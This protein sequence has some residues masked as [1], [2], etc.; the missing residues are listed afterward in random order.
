GEEHDEP[1]L[2]AEVDDPVEHARSLAAAAGADRAL[3]DLGL[4]EE[5]SRRDHLLA[6]LE[7]GPGKLHE[8]SDRVAG[9]DAPRLVE[10]ALL[11]DE[12]DERD[13]VPLD[14]LP[15]HDERRAGRADDDFAGAEHV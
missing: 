2:E 4:E 11:P 8:P 5:A 10:V 13:A 6:G 15:R 1:V 12:H 14:S 7:V 3:L 9:D